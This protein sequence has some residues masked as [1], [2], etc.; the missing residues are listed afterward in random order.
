[1]GIP[2][3]LVRV[4][5][6]C[7]AVLLVAAGH[8]IAS[9]SERPKTHALATRGP[10]ATA[11]ATPAPSVIP[12]AKPV[13]IRVSQAAPK[14]AP[15]LRTLPFAY[16]G[17]FALFH[18]SRHVERVGFH[19]ASDVRDRVLT[20][21]PTAVAPKVL[22]SRSRGTPARTAADIVVPPHEVI[23]APVSGI[24]KRA[25][26]YHLYCKYPD[27]FVV[28]SP[29]GH[30]EL[31]V[32]MLHITGLH[33]RPGDNVVAG[34]TI[35]ATHATHFPFVSEVDPFTV[36]KW[37]HVHIEVTQLVVPSAK[38]QPGKGLAFGCA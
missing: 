17:T 34:K 9:G 29:N 32:K 12:S 20:I 2:E 5:L 15:D 26:G 18:P 11:T 14:P 33:V 13:V 1:M 4:A 31:E 30:P 24:V 27:S 21:A 3:R 7:L 25:G 28:I 6:A 10:L 8:A 36:H 19:Q 35:V 23:Y 22:A 16:V 38:P 37:P